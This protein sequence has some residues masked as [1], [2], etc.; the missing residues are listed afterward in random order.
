MIGDKIN[1]ANYK[2]SHTSF[3]LL[4]KL[5]RL[6]P[7]NHDIIN[8]KILCINIHLYIYRIEPNLK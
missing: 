3:H 7:Q 2:L 8:E 6:F 1:T 4:K 5:A